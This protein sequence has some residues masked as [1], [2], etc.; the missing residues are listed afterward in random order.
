MK[1]TFYAAKINVHENIFNQNLQE[2]IRV[3]IPKAI[4]AMPTIRV[5]SFNLSFTDVVETIFEGNRIIAGNIT[6]SK[7]SSQKVRI[8]SST[9]IVKSEYELAKTSFFVYHPE[10]E[11]I[12]YEVNSSIN[13]DE[14]RSFFTKIL[15][16]DNIIGE[17]IIKTIPEPYKIR[18]EIQAMQ[19]V[20]TIHFQLIHP[21]PGKDAFNLYNKIIKDNQLKELEIKMFNKKGVVLRSTLPVIEEF[22]GQNEEVIILKPYIDLNEEKDKSMP[23]PIFDNGA[24][25]GEFNES[26]ENGISLVESGYGAVSIKGF[27]EITIPSAG[28]GKRKKKIK[29]NRFFS[30]Q[31]SVRMIKTDEYSQERLIRRI[32]NFIQDVKNKV[33]KEGEQNDTTEP[34]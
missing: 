15:S 28:K 7:H 9:N 23:N 6:K 4:L 24:E 32:I 34:L 17:V 8:G 21:N 25:T 27:D 33:I 13:D 18:S 12:C 11:I 29:K 1:K 16:R 2:I 19:T 10:S 31:R 30:S 5:N 26:I 22:S 14:F 20:T 3:H